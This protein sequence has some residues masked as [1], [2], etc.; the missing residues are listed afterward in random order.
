[1][2]CFL[3][4]LIAFSIQP[5]WAT[6]APVK[7]GCEEALLSSGAGTL[8]R[9]K[10]PGFAAMA[11]AEG[12]EF[13]MVSVSHE[14]F[15]QLVEAS[16]QGEVKLVASGVGIAGSGGEQG[17]VFNHPDERFNHSMVPLHKGHVGHWAHQL[18]GDGSDSIGMGVRYKGWNRWAVGLVFPVEILDFFEF[19]ITGSSTVEERKEAMAYGRSRPYFTSASLDL[20]K[21]RAVI[22]DKI[23]NPTYPESWDA[24]S[25]WHFHFNEGI[26]LWAMSFVWIPAPLADVILPGSADLPGMNARNLP[27]RGQGFQQRI[28]SQDPDASR[29]WTNLKPFQENWLEFLNVEESIATW[30][31]IVP[32]WNK[33]AA[34][35][36]AKPKRGRIFLPP[37]GEP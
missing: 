32:D 5:L 19:E 33:V 25:D 23:S 22:S 12:I 9:T 18:I 2:K 29:G 20:E 3:F 1:M 10:Q 13:L 11:R 14:K 24:N 36:N 26:P 8:S 27:E 6:K 28:F 21:F 15:L 17:Q 31:N 30:F 35:I 34:A 16:Q 37:R 4:L 7:R